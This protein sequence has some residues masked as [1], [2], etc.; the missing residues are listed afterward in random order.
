MITFNSRDNDSWDSYHLVSTLAG[1]Y[2]VWL[3]LSVGWCHNRAVIKKKKYLSGVV[4]IKMKIKF[5]DGG[6]LLP[7]S[8]RFW[9]GN[10]EISAE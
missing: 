6:D 9:F 4:E 10:L 8:T 3:I 1:F 5:E 2:A 7:R